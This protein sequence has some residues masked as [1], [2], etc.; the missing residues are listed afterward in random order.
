MYWKYICCILYAGIIRLFKWKVSRK[1]L[2]EEDVFVFQSRFCVDV[3]YVC[4]FSKGQCQSNYKS[5]D[6]SLVDEFTVCSYHSWMS[7]RS[8]P[9]SSL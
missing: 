9:F 3:N 6:W 2:Q 8:T 1:H 5:L 7:L 4:L